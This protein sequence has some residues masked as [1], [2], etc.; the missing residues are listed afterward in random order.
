MGHHQLNSQKKLNST[1]PVLRLRFQM[2]D[3]QSLKTDKNN[4]AQLKPPAEPTEEAP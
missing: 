3:F 4:S 2:S 1:F